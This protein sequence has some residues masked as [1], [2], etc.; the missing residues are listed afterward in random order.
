MILTSP[1]NFPRSVQTTHQQFF[2]TIS[3]F[4]QSEPP[5]MRVVLVSGGVISGVGKGK[6]SASYVIFQTWLNT[7][8]SPIGIIGIALYVFS[9]SF[10][11]LTKVLKK[12]VAL[13]F[14]SRPWVF[15]SR[16]DTP[17][18][19]TTSRRHLLTPKLL[20]AKN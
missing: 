13:D 4:A 16:Y 8:I 15:A 3:P 11:P 14:C 2:S 17:P 12:P 19:T 18:I 7:Y 10:H 5:K 1:Y 6:F 20:G 9:C